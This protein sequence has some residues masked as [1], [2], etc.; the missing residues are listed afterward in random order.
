MEKQGLFIKT[1]DSETKNKLLELGFKLVSDQMGEAV[2]L[3]DAH[4]RF[5][6]KSMKSAVYSDSIFI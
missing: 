5:D 3:N 1:R 6:R 2:F 4:I